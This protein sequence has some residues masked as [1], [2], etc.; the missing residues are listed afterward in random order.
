MYDSFIHFQKIFTQN[1]VNCELD[2]TWNL[3]ANISVPIV[4]L[5]FAIPSTFIVHLSAMVKA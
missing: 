3:C 5:L 2:I 4:K 1:N